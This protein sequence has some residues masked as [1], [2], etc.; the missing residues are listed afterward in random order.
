VAEAVLAEAELPLLVVPARLRA[1]SAGRLLVDSGREGRPAG[2]SAAHLLVRRVPDGLSAGEVADVVGRPVLA[3]LGHDRSA[4]L[5]G[6][7]GQPPS[8]AARSPLG[9]VA[10][11]VLTQPV[12]S[13]GAAA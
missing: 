11:R 8:V 3:E 4:V 10:R 2:W 9:A 1:A 6:E 13:A 7:R 5:R 12:G